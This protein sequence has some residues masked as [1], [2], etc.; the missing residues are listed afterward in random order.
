MAAKRRREIALE[1]VP[2]VFLG[3]AD[4][5]GRFPPV[6]PGETRVYCCHFEPWGIP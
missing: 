3:G 5:S 4:E 2:G 1:G 6:E